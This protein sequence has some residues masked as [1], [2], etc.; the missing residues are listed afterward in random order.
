MPLGFIVT[1]IDAGNACV[2]GID[3]LIV[4]K[5]TGN[6]AVSAHV[7]CFMNTAPAASAADHHLFHRLSGIIVPH[8]LKLKRM[9]DFFQQRLKISWGYL[10]DP[11][12]GIVRQRR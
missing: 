12:A 6:Q 5:I 9:S 3:H 1:G 10:S 8:T 2:H 11:C 7:D 4:L